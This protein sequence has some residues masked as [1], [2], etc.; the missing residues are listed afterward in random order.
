MEVAVPIVS[1]V[2]PVEPGVRGIFTSASEA[3]I[4]KLEGEDRVRWTVAPRPML[5][6][7]I[8]ELAELP[9]RTLAGWTV[10]LAIMKSGRMLKLILVECIVEPLVATMVAV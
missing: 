6:S 8:V 1:T 4:P 3:V 9:A 10:L 5:L 7:E 2:V